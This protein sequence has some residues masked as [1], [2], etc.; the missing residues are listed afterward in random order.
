MGG[1]I[2]IVAIGGAYFMRYKK[3]EFEALRNAPNTSDETQRAL[4]AEL[5]RL[6]SQNAELGS[7]LQRLEAEQANANLGSAVP[8]KELN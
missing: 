7:R 5:K 3:M 2:A 1:L 6:H 4:L 8:T